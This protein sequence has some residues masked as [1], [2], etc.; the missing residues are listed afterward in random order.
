MTRKI[1]AP[2]CDFCAK[3]IVSEMKYGVDIV[4][5]NGVKGTFVKCD[6]SADMCQDCFLQVCRNGFK[7][8]WIKGIKNPQTGIWDWNDLEVQSKF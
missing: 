8:K 3:D 7:P 2:V 1:I 6:N 4:Q 5:R